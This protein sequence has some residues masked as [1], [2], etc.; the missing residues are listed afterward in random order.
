M[1]T[2]SW[3]FVFLAGPLYANADHGNSIGG[4][5]RGDCIPPTL[6]TDNAGMQLVSNG[7]AV[8]GNEFDVKYFKQDVPTQWVNVGEP[9]VITLTIF[10]NT[11]PQNLEYVGLLMGIE[12]RFVAG[13]T[14]QSHPVQIHWMKDREGTTT[15]VEQSD[16]LIKDVL[17]TESIVGRNNIITFEFTLS[18]I[19]DTDV[20]TVKMWDVAKNQW[21]NHFYE[22]IK[23]VSS[24]GTD[25]KIPEWVKSNAGWWAEGQISDDSFVQAIQ[26]LIKNKVIVISQP[27]QESNLGSDKIP[28]WV[29][30]NAGWWAE[31]Q[32]SDDSFVQA[33][34]YL[35]EA[36]IIKA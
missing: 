24:T 20:I 13:V 9:V 17:I 28:E 30:S 16:D 2:I 18:Q 3:M 26:Y 31:G 10:E 23:I 6:G 25:M 21:T 7:F 8:N 36:G 12:E 1:I 35:I 4:G 19:F 33:I 27:T 5:C 29:K 34:Q 14:V 22:A 15:T 32:I 11:Y